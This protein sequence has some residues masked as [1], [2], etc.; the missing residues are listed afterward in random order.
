MII[1]TFD[2]GQEIQLP[3]CC[4]FPNP[5]FWNPTKTLYCANCDRTYVTLSW[6]V[7]K[8]LPPNLVEDT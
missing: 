3:R 4:D 2:E 6:V 8:T 1:F 5:Q 7:N